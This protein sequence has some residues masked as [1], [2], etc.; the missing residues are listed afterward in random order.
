MAA[1]ASAGQR[2]PV[3]RDAWLDLLHGG[4]CAGCARPGRSLCR[5]CAASLPRSATAVAPD[6]CPPG[7][8]PCFA[9]GEYD[10]LLRA[11]LLAHKEQAVHDL[12][13]PLAAVLAAAV[14]PLLVPGA[15]TVLV[16]V[17]SSLAVVRARGHDP[18]ARLA[19]GAAHRLRGPGDGVAVRP[20]LRQR[21]VVA[22]QAG[23]DLEGRRRNREGSLAVRAE[24]RDRLARARRGRPVVVVVVDDVLTTGATVREAQRALEAGGVPVRGV[25]VLAATRRRRGRPG[26][27]PGRPALPAVGPSH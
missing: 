9:A 24:V 10:A 22:D 27:P 16:P 15:A 23:L 11:L 26:D 5:A 6:P 13:G 17:P 20:L 4:C 18:L 14:R 12:R 7:L 21:G 8:V 25:A 2:G 3:L 19:R 1:G